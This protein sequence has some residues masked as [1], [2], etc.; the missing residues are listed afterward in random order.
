MHRPCLFGTE[1]PDPKKPGRLGRVHRHEYVMTPLE[2]LASLPEA[3]SFLREDITLEGLQEQARSL[4]DIEAVKQ[5]R[6][7]TRPCRSHE[8]VLGSSGMR[9]RL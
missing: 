2:K 7:A 1:V 9:S 4:T 3:S 5:V 6:E 8:N